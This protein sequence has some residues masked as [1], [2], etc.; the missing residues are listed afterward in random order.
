M[1]GAIDMQ[2]NKLCDMKI[3]NDKQDILGYEN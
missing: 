1:K 2:A 3:M